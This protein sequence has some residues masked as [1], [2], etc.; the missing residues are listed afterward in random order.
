[1]DA[2]QDE[3]G[4]MYAIYVDTCVRNPL[5]A[6]GAPIACSQFVD[7]LNDFLRKQKLLIV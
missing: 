6:L 5:Y 3:L 7:Q 2:L 4:K 1:V